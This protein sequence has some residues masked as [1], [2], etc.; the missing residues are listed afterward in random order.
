MSLTLKE[1]Q[2][3]RQYQFFPILARLAKNKVLLKLHLM[4]KICQFRGKKQKREARDLTF[5]LSLSMV[6]QVVAGG[7][8]GDYV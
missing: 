4:E 7:I 3:L 6:D 2:K 1:I 8:E 5:S